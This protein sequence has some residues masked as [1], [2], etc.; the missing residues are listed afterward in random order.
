MGSAGLRRPR[1]TRFLRWLVDSGLRS[2]P[3][4]PNSLGSADRL[5]EHGRSDRMAP[6]RPEAEVVSFTRRGLE[7]AGFVGRVPFEALRRSSPCPAA[8]GV[9]VVVSAAPATESFA[10]LSCG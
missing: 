3:A 8:S 4:K 7:E 10:D 2:L 6:K 1:S 5:A 9:Y